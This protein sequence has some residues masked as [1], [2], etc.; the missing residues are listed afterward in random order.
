MTADWVQQCLKNR[1][2]VKT[3]RERLQDLGWFM[4]CLKEPL[5]RLANRQD[6]K[7]GAFFEKR[8]KSVAVLDDA[9]LLTICAYID[10]NPLAAG[11]VPVP[12]A[13]PH[14]SIKTR[15]EHAQEQG[16]TSDL[17]RSRRWQRGGLEHVGRSGGIAL[18]LPDRGS[19]GAGFFT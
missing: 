12:E 16:R 15:V 19:S 3:L 5:A 7:H 18:A 14:T 6:K 4:K 8:Y 17:A 13:S 9:A 1:R 11:V 2:K 10:L